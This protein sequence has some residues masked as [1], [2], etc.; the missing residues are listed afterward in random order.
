M[1]TLEDRFDLEVLRAQ[2]VTGQ[3]LFRD[4]GEAQSAM[5]EALEDALNVLWKQGIVIPH[6]QLNEMTEALWSRVYGRLCPN[7]EDD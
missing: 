3:L 6:A 7:F 5:C 4:R 1:L 2:F